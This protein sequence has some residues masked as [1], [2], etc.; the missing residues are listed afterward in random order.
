[1]TIAY[2]VLTAFAVLGWAPILIRFYR[3]W[4]NRHNP[5]SLSICAAILLLIWLAVAG[6]WEVSGD[7]RSEVVT[8]ASTAV[9]VVVSIY[10][11]FAFRM[12]ENKFDEKRKD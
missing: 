12:A 4:T 3:N 1:M 10:A 6:I 8:F 7:V 5:I 2:F 11:N 9:S